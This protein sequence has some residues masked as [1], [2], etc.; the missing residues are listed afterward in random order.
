MTA[1]KCAVVIPVYLSHIALS[2]EQ[3]LPTL[4]GLTPN[5]KDPDTAKREARAPRRGARVEYF[6]EFGCRPEPAAN[7]SANGA[8][9]LP[10]GG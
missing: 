7:T 5:H 2:Y 10:F 9:P 1:M 3:A 8:G 6:V 4:D